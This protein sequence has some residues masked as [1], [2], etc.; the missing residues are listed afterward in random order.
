[1]NLLKKYMLFAVT[2]GISQLT[3]GQIV[4]VDVMPQSNTIAHTGTSRMQLT[5]KVTANLPVSETIASTQLIIRAGNAYGPVLAKLSR[6]LNRNYPAGVSTQSFPEAVVVP[7]RLVYRAK[8]MGYRALA[9]QRLFTSNANSMGN[10]TTVQMTS[11]SAARFS[12]TRIQ[13]KFETPDGEFDSLVVSPQDQ[14][15][16]AYAL[17]YYQGSGLLKATW[18]VARPSST[19]GQPVF[20]PITQVVQLQP[21]A[22]LTKI[23]TP[24]LPRSMTGAYL[25]RLHVHQPT[26][27]IE[28]PV[29]RYIVR[30]ATPERT[31]SSNSSD[32]DND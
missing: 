17:I 31:K 28:S 22:G 29:L 7:N 18:E 9:F 27:V 2:W 23:Y 24:E 16:Q 30:T 5:W 20:A 19:G 15:V 32:T 13:L 3:L 1:M 11:A 25:L 14:E 10:T 21:S 4:S 8:K 12:I 6:T 26:P